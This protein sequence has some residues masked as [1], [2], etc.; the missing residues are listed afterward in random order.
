M[1]PITIRQLT[2]ADRAAWRRMRRL[3]WPDETA[4][5]HDAAID[6]IL[7]AEDAWGFIADPGSPRQAKW[8]ALISLGIPKLVRIHKIRLQQLLFRHYKNFLTK[9]QPVGMRST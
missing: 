1:T 7:H 4:N 2:S 9:Y 8:T 5:G 6:E 3:L